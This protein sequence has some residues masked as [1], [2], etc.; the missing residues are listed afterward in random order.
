MADPVATAST[1]LLSKAA[2]IANDPGATTAESRA[3]KE[4]VARMAQAARFAKHFLGC[5]PYNPKKRLLDRASTLIEKQQGT[6]EE[7]TQI[8]EFVSRVQYQEVRFRRESIKQEVWDRFVVG[9]VQIDGHIEGPPPIFRF[10]SAYN[11]TC[12]FTRDMWIAVGTERFEEEHAWHDEDCDMS[13]LLFAKDWGTKVAFAKSP[14]VE[15]MHFET[16]FGANAM[17]LVRQLLP[18]FSGL[19]DATLVELIRISASAVSHRDSDAGWY[20]EFEFPRPFEYE[21]KF[22]ADS[23]VT[24]SPTNVAARRVSFGPGVATADTKSP[25]KVPKDL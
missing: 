6:E 17:T 12:S 14:S 1:E 13:R 8:Q 2:S 23:L 5:A 25:V 22:V 9:Q 3:I 4:E 15:E 16:F 24:G 19:S 10:Q 20:S 7:A 18:R 11:E 21:D